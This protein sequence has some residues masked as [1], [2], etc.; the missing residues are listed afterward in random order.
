M[1][2][3]TIDLRL[4]AAIAE[5]GGITAAAARLGLTKSMVSRELAAMED[6]LGARLV[7][8]TTRKVSLTE[9]GELLAVYARRVVE[10]LDNAE[11]AI[12]ATREAPR[13]DL[14]ISAPFSVLRFVIAPHLGAFRARYPEI[15]LNIDAS[16]RLAD[17]VEED[18]D[19]ALRI[20]ALPPSS[21]VARLLATIP[22]ILVAAPSYIA[23]KGA[24]AE[25]R[26]LLTHDIV[27]LRK[28]LSSEVWTLRG[29]GGETAPVGVK[30]VASVHDPGI[31]L[32]LAEQ[33]M[34]VAPM[35]LSY[36]RAS[37]G[38]GHLVRVLPDWR[39]RETPL[40]AVY[41]SRRILAPKV[42]AFVDF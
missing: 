34:G 42:R 9:T 27:N 33:G 7:Q 39:L 16:M 12:E 25:P 40:H 3:S 28:D 29:D 19:V 38:R 22:I 31:L 35:P 26:D 30:P 1:K 8:R 6:R 18:V 20:G 23:R 24:P 36:A 2:L 41:P 15:R 21:L 4:F 32:D 10:E 37:L 17:L 13:G 11:A 5:T 14:K